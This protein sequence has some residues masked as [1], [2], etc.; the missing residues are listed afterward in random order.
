MIDEWAPG[1][2]WGPEQIKEDLA[3]RDI[4]YAG[5]EVGK[6]EKLSKAQ[7]LPS[8]RGGSVRLVDWVS[9]SAR[10]L[11]EN[12][13]LCEVEDC[14]QVVPRLVGRVH[15][16]EGEQSEVA[17]LLVERGICKWYPEKEI[18]RFRGSYVKYGMFGVVKPGKAVEGRETLRVI[19]N[20]IPSNS[21]HSIIPGSVHR[22]PTITQ[23]TS[24]GPGE[25]VEVS[26]AD[27]TSAFYLFQLPSAWHRRLAFNIDCLGSELGAGY[28]SKTKYTLCACVLPMGWSSAVGI[29]EEAKGHWSGW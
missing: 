20:L 10:R 2:L 17:K 5:E 21:I 4:G 14:G 12:P 26:Q 27:I 25:K 15:I 8:L 3:K 16:Q 18:H 29:M 13:T 9:P 23:W 28:D 7:I 1:L 22:L 6:V 19:M 24:I 11:L